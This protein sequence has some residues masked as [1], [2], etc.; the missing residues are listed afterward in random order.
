MMGQIYISLFSIVFT[1]VILTSIQ[2]IFE[3]YKPRTT[4]EIYEQLMMLKIIASIL[5][6]IIVYWFG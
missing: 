4:V 1:F 2:L 3:Y 6:G 5:M